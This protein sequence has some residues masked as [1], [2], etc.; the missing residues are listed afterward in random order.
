MSPT[1]RDVQERL[2][3][4][5]DLY[6]SDTTPVVMP[7]AADTVQFL[8]AFLSTPRGP[9]LNNRP[10]KLKRQMAVEGNRG[11][12]GEA[13][14]LRVDV[15]K[16]D[17]VKGPVCRGPGMGG[18]VQRDSLGEHIDVHCVGLEEETDGR[19]SEGILL[20]TIEDH[21]WCGLWPGSFCQNVLQSAQ[22]PR[23]AADFAPALGGVG[24]AVVLARS[25]IGVPRDAMRSVD[26]G[27]IAWFLPE[28]T[29]QCASP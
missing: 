17:E 29:V 12:G 5:R 13:I 19:V 26:D 20:G 6:Y 25:A 16:H 28:S 7:V 10:G 22:F 4:C 21:R 8:D 23:D 9:S 15:R 1:R 2:T 24:D 11:S 3:D 18:V 14:G 27:E